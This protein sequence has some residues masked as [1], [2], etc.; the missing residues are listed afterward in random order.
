[1]QEQFQAMPGT[2]AIKPSS[3]AAM[4]IILAAM[5]DTMAQPS[6][7]SEPAI[8]RRFETQSQVEIGNTKVRYTA[9][10]AESFLS[11][12]QG[13]RTASLVSTSYLRT[14]SRRGQVRP[15]VF[16]FNGGP[17]SS[18]VWLHMGLVGPRRIDFTDEVQPETTPPFRIADNAD[19][20]LDVADVVLFDPP[21]TGF[22]RV[23]AD[24]KPEQFYGVTQ[25]AQATVRFIEDWVRQHGR[26]Q[27]PRFLMGESYG[28]VRAAVVAKLLT[29]GPMMTGSMEGLTLNGVILLGQA[30]GA[31]G[32]DDT[33]FANALPTL[34]ATAWYH[35][36]VPKNGRTL[37]QHVAD[38]EAFAATDYIGALY[39]GR[40]LDEANRVAIASRIAELTGLPE[41]FVRQQDLRISVGEF[42]NELL[43]EEGKQVGRYDS[44]YT[45][46]IAANGNDPVAD[47]PAMAQY[48]PGFVAVLNSYMRDELGVS[49]AEDYLAIEF[50]NVNAQ[51]DWGNGPGIPSDRNSAAD[52]ATAMR[53]NPDLWLYVGSGYYDLATTLGSAAYTIAHADF[54]PERVWVRSYES[55]HMPYLGPDSRAKL[56][57]DLRAF[58]QQASSHSVEPKQ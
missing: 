21:G 51:W 43:R 57:S 31:G 35:G 23:L 24:G 55:G 2:A 12:D 6:E 34:A 19:S 50:R 9:V 29:G 38:A 27:S 56:A 10:V 48:V 54:P 8:P 11:N 52:L 45:L 36:K 18:S 44:R 58:I 17:G 30:M 25:D 33:A 1:M 26:W 47:D 49:L 53:R 7:E 46:P 37:E 40:R 22:S 15:V 39:A 16:V 42:S 32:D 28:T 20:I 41:E 13:Q 5:G 14:D 3:V 4:L